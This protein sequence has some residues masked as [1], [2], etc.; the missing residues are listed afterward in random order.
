MRCY[1]QYS[2]MARINRINKP[3]GTSLS[4]L[5]GINWNAEAWSIRRY[6]IPLLFEFDHEEHLVRHIWGN[7]NWTNTDNGTGSLL[8][9]GSITFVRLAVYPVGNSFKLALICVQEDHDQSAKQPLDHVNWGATFQRLRKNDSL[10]LGCTKRQRLLLLLLPFP[11]PACLLLQHSTP[12]TPYIRVGHE[13]RL[14]EFDDDDLM[15]LW[16]FDEFLLLLTY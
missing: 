11:P 13:V 16:D 7:S 5:Y 1:E 9:I 15:I 12:G 8:H 6:G 4:V 10:A 14:S 2:S 3:S